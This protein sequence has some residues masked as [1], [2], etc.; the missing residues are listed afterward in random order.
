MFSGVLIGFVA[1]MRVRLSTDKLLLSYLLQHFQEFCEVDYGIKMLS[2]KLRTLCELE[3]PTFHMGFDP[4][5]AKESGKWSQAIHATLISFLI[6]ATG[7]L[8]SWNP[9][10]TEMLYP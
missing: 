1:E 7:S 10:L 8:S 9:S 2:R 6:L 3:W 4:Q 5:N